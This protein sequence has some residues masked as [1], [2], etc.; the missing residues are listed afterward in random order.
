MIPSARNP[1]A[2]IGTAI[3]KM[4]NTAL[5]RKLRYITTAKKQPNTAD[6]IRNRKPAQASATSKAPSGISIMNPSEK[7]G[8]FSACNPA[9][10]MSAVTLCNEGTRNA[11]LGTRKNKN[12]NGAS[13]N[14]KRR[15]PSA[16]TST[17]SNIATTSNCRPSWMSRTAAMSQSADSTGIS[18][19]GQKLGCGETAAIT[20]R[21]SQSR[22]PNSGRI[23]K[24]WV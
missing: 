20:T 21:R 17:T 11:P 9:T 3:D 16:T 2:R 10:L 15:G 6:A 24:Q 12:N 22:K 18:T 19:S 14:Q 5:L 23:R 7:T 1:L 8:I 4:M 13:N